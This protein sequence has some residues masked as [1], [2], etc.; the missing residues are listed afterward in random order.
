MLWP[1]E[2]SAIGRKSKLGG[3]RPFGATLLDSEKTFEEEL[4]V[5]ELARRTTHNG[6]DNRISTGV[7]INPVLYPASRLRLIFGLEDVC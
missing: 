1:G 6:S 4:L 2:C 7:P 5:Q 3:Q